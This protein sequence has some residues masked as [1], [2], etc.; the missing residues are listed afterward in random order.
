MKAL[1][2]DCAGFIGSHL[3]MLMG[4]NGEVCNIGSGKRISIK[5]LANRGSAK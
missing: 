3:A 2:T 5:E 4:K 1:V